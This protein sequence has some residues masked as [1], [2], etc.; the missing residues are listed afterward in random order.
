MPMKPETIIK[1]FF[2][3]KLKHANGERI[4]E[5]EILGMSTWHI[6]SKL[7]DCFKRYGDKPR[8]VS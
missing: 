5:D 4:T 7:I 6:E 8:R 2:A 1:H 3:G